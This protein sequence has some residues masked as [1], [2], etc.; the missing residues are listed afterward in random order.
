MTRPFVY[1]RDDTVYMGCNP[2]PAELYEMPSCRKDGKGSNLVAQVGHAGF[3][4][5]R[6]NR[7]E[8]RLEVGRALECSA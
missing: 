4:Y 7:E 5:L 6:L 8:G 1:V 3:F 2:V